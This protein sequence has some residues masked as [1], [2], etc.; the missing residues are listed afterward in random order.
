MIQACELDV[1]VDAVDPVRGRD[2]IAIGPTEQ[3]IDRY[4]AVE[5][6]D[7]SG[8]AILPGLINAHTHIPM[9]L[10]RGLVADLELGVALSGHRCL[11]DIS[12]DCLVRPPAFP[13]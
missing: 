6:V 7:C 13:R 11:A 9:S 12:R 8:C 10:L 5:A 4:Q 3:L 1:F 2:I